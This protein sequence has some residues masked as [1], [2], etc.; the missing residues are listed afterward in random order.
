MASGGLDIRISSI[1]FQKSYIDW[2]QQSPTET[3]QKFNIFFQ[4]IEMKMN[5]RTVFHSDFA[6]FRIPAASMASTASTTSM[7]SMTS[8]ASSYQNF[9]DH[10]L[11]WFSFL[12]LS[13]TD[14]QL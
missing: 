2:P 1:C 10:D 4:N 9:T 11:V 8:T 7:A 14:F 12:K 5:S 6:G 3:L 13:L